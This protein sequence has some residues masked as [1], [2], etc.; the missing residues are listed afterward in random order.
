MTLRPTSLIMQV[1]VDP[2]KPTGEARLLNLAMKV[3]LVVAIISIVSAVVMFAY[4]F[5]VIDGW[6][7]NGHNVQ[8]DSPEAVGGGQWEVWVA[9]VS[10]VED[11]GNWRAVLVKD[12]SLEDDMNPLTDGSTTHMTFTDLAGDGKLTSGD[13]FRIT[14]DPGSSYE[15]VIIWID[16][17]NQ[18]GAAGWET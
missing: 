7:I 18:V 11:L 16:T 14:C 3:I 17:G 4:D 15:L 2:G 9:G 13:F 12:G 5:P 6:I 10:N 1:Q 8:F